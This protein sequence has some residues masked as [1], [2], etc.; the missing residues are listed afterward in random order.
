MTLTFLSNTFIIINLF[1]L[2]SN[3]FFNSVKKTVELQIFK[4]DFF[5][6]IK[7]WGENIKL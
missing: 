7:L 5:Y 2:Y 3:R 4:N 6:F 1:T